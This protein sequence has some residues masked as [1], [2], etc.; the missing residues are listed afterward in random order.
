MSNIFY[1]L[2]FSFYLLSWTGIIVF[3]LIHIKNLSFSSLFIN[4]S[5]LLPIKKKQK[6]IYEL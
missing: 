1:I 3:Y 2:A 4:L 6:K 5:L